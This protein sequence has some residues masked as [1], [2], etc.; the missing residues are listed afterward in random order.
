MKVGENSL[1]CA[2]LASGRLERTERQDTVC[3]VLI[4]QPYAGCG[5]ARIAM[6]PAKQ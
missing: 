1:S 4:L 5:P 3:I 2:A 6:Y